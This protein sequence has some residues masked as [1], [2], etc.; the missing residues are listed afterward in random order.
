MN[1]RNKILTTPTKNSFGFTTDELEKLIPE[2]HGLELKPFRNVI[3]SVVFNTTT[4]E[5]VYYFEDVIKAVN[6]GLGSMRRGLEDG[7]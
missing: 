6:A 2:F 3:S 5:P 4:G 1:I 7:N